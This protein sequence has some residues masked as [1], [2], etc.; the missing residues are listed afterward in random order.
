MRKELEQNRRL[1][2]EVEKEAM[3]SGLNHQVRDFKKEIDIS[4]DRENRIWLQRSKTLWAA[5]RDKNSRFFHSKTTRRYRKNYIGKI[6]NNDGIWSTGREEVKDFMVRYYQELFTSAN[7]NQSDVVVVAVHSIITPDL[8]EKL[9]MDFKAW[10]VQAAIK[11]MAPLKEPG[12]DGSL[13]FFSKTT[14]H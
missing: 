12:L 9:S 10:E 3:T 13:Q 6:R 4:L 2:A 8:N 14:G 5:Q 11:Q 1:L 7:P